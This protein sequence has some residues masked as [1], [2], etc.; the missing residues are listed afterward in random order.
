MADISELYSYHVCVRFMR[1]CSLFLCLCI[2][3]RTQKQLEKKH[4][5]LSLLLPKFFEVLD[6]AS[7]VDSSQEARTYCERFI[8]FVIDLLVSCASR[9]AGLL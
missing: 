1:C 4:E 2:Y 9:S 5:F 7:S 3:F 6:V 8:E